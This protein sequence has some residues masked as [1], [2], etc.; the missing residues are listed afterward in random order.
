MHARTSP[1]AAPRAIGL[2]ALLLVALLVFAGAARADVY[3]SADFAPSV[4]SDKDDYAPGELVTL[5]GALWQ[6]GEV[7]HVRVN[8]DQGST[9]SRDAD[10]TA[11]EL[12]MITDRFNLPGW[13]VATYS[14][15]AVGSSGAVATYAFTDSSVT[16]TFPAAGAT[17]TL[18]QWDAGCGTAAGDL[19]GTAE[20]S[21]VGAVQVSLKRDSD[22][23][24][25]NGTSWVVVSEAASFRGAPW[26][27]STGNWSSA[28]SSASF[29]GSG[30]YTA[31]ARILNKNGNEIAG[32][33]DTG[34][35]T[36]T[37][38]VQVKQDQTISFAG[39]TGLV[40]GDG[41]ADLGATASSG[42]PVAYAGSTPAVC[43]VV[44]GKVHVVAAGTCTITA[45][46]GGN[47]SWNPAPDVTRS[48]QIAR[49]PL[50]V[51][52][53]DKSRVYGDDNPVLT[54]TVTGVRNNDDITATF[55]TSAT[56]A[57]NVGDYAIV[58]HVDG[59]VSN[60]AVT[61]TNGK[62]T[63]TKAPLTA[64]AADTSRV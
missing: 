3:A 61:L 50:T 13:F 43:T 21:N 62:L 44:G 23:R 4:W 49:A 16:M 35:V 5:S 2:L 37:F 59:D 55:S 30:S 25:W 38:T 15:R 47:G 46:Q 27:A 42:L 12:G 28:F 32:G 7:V 8:D 57:S 22:G 48:F 53:G 39:V 40:Y 51:A 10:V 56:P 6:P 24:Y 36:R 1:A 60:Y 34:R 63:V 33:Q 18:G 31:I 11:D 58:P 20:G 54:G 29:S 64:K 45:S 19:C 14:V 41:D 9:W 26:N 52:A 17:Y